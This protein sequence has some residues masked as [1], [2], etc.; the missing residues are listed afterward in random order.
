VTI[1]KKQRKVI[2]D[3]SKGWCWYCGQK[4]P[5]KGW[6]VDHLNPVFRVINTKTKAVNAFGEVPE[7]VQTLLEN[8]GML[9]PENDTI[10]NMVPSCAPCNLFKATF[11][12]DQ[13]RKEI[14]LQV[15]RAR[16]SSVNFRTAERFGLI[17]APPRPVIFWFECQYL[18]P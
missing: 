14:Q 10:D 9:N 8:D 7:S 11:T 4:L 5:D 16:R 17:E 13:F 3:K 12:I 15:E 18:I 6:H 2:W 1:S